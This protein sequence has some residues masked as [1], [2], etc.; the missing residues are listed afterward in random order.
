MV[1]RPTFFFL[2]FGEGAQVD[3]WVLLLSGPGTFLETSLDGAAECADISGLLPSLPGARLAPCW[4][5][6]WVDAERVNEIPRSV[7]MMGGLQRRVREALDLL[8]ARQF[9]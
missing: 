2:R 8:R 7:Q 1:N 3:W 9:R 4:G 5:H 6:A